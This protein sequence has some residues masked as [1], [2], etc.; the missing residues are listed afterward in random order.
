[1]MVFL[2]VFLGGCFIS[3]KVDERLRDGDGDGVGI[4][5][6]C[7]DWDSDNYPGADERCDGQDNN[8]DGSIDEAQSV[9]AGIW[10][11]D[12][13]RDGYGNEYAPVQACAAPT[14]YRADKT[15]C[16]DTDFSINPGSAEICDNV[17]NNCDSI[18]D[19]SGALDETIW[20]L[21][22]DGDGYGD[23]NDAGTLSCAH[24]AD[25]TSDNSDCDDSNEAIN[26]GAVEYCDGN[27]N[28][29]DGAE[30]GIVSL[31]KTTGAWSS[32][33][34]TWAAGDLGSPVSVTLDQSGTVWVCPGSYYVTIE[35]SASWLVIRSPDGQD[36]AVLSGG[37]ASRVIHSSG[38][39]TLENL[40]IV[41]GTTSEFGGVLY[42]SGILM[43]K[44]SLI[45]GGSAYK[46]GNLY[47][48]GCSLTVDTVTFQGGHA[49]YGGGIYNYHGNF[50]AIALTLSDN[51]AIDGGGYFGKSDNTTIQ[52]STISGNGAISSG[53]GVYLSGSTFTMSDTT[54]EGNEVGSYGAGA[55]LYD[56]STYTMSSS[57]I[58]GNI[59]GLIGGGLYLEGS[60]D[61]ICTG[62][63]ESTFGIWGNQALAGGGAFLGS[64]SDTLESITCDWTGTTDNDLY[65]IILASTIYYTFSDNE[66]FLC[67]SG[68]CD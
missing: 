5:A 25:T 41:D 48:N 8:C 9:D 51:S 2:L 12:A 63:S 62:T 55:S 7:D 36:Y 13:D 66:S 15:D 31:E 16:D 11:E 19:E 64:S 65:D 20:Y 37:G 34:S 46:G 60:S 40:D 26:P 45:G 56:G 43:I 59:A 14:D 35:A 33:T 30:E 4:E 58:Q 68:L 32:L 23:Q 29:C 17:D 47:C 54:I 57:N 38:D 27:D 52:S 42:S 10:Y 67:A 50:D 21:D 6:D 3:A 61:A 28:D 44:N 39:L 49:E 24:P 22:Q 1:M 18:V 53:G